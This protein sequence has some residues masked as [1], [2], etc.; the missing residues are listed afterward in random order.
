MQKNE[1]PPNTYRLVHVLSRKCIDRKIGT[2][3]DFDTSF[4]LCV[5]LRCAR[6]E[7]KRDPL[8]LCTCARFLVVSC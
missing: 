7:A 2:L 4:S 5:I 6:D 3:I 1:R 8:L